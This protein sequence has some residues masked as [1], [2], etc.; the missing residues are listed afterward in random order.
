MDRHVKNNTKHIVLH[1]FIH[2]S[3]SKVDPDFTKEVFDN[4]DERLSN[5]GFEVEQTPF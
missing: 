3:E 2:L 5:S 4:I 1:S